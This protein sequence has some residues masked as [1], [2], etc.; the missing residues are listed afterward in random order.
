MKVYL[1]H[2][3]CRGC[4]NPDYRML[5]LPSEKEFYL[6]YAKEN[7]NLKICKLLSRITN[8]LQA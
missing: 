8:Y 5:M 2:A 1:T 7:S 3:W 4:K 6:A